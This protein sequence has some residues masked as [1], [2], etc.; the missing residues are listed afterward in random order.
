MGKDGPLELNRRT[1]L[2]APIALPLLAALGGCES[3]R[4]PEAAKDK[5]VKPA[6]STA[7]GSGLVELIKRDPSIHLDL[8]YATTNNF[9]GRVLYPSARAFLVE[10]AAAGLVR[11]HQAAAKLG[12]GVTIFDAY[13]PWRVTK[14]LWDATVPAKR[15]Y[16]ANPRKGSRHNRGCAVDMT[17]HSL[18]TGALLDM[19]TEFDE[20]SSK[21]HRDYMGATEAQI[22]NRATLQTLMEAQGFIGISN[23]WWHFDFAGWERYPVL[24]VPFEKL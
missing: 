4:R 17:L 13:R 23:E 15:D 21:A 1:L 18:S 12:L 7:P 6:K 19:P 24:D 11:A 10:E 16:V 22:A 3:E 5:P 14:Q 20:F 8:R 2:Y 9:T